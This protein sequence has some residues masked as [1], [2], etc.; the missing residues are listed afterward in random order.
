MNP[1]ERNVGLGVSVGEKKQS[2]IM[3][4][5][6]GFRNDPIRG[7]EPRRYPRYWLAHGTVIQHVGTKLTEN[8]VIMRGFAAHWYSREFEYIITWRIV[9]QWSKRSGYLPKTN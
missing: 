8:A 2:A 5:C 6:D 1:E 4:G 3:F 9:R 7:L